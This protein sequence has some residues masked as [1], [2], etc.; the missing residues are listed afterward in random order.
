[1]IILKKNQFF[2]KTIPS[3]NPVFGLKKSPKQRKPGLSPGFL[4]E[5]GRFY[6]LK[7]YFC[8]KQALV[9]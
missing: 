3:K 4:F 9:T 8:Q 2:K 6:I 5:I 7:D 1:L